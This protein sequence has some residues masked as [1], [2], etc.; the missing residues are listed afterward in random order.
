MPGSAGTAL[1]A[2]DFDRVQGVLALAMSGL[3]NRCG[4][5]PFPFGVFTAVDEWLAFELLLQPAG[6]PVHFCFAFWQTTHAM[7]A[8]LN[9]HTRFIQVHL[10]QAFGG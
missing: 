2:W 5:L 8:P 6:T 1:R 9:S 3:V 10:S 7:P 4:I